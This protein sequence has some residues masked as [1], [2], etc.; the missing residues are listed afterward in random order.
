MLVGFPLNFRF[1]LQKG[2]LAISIFHVRINF[3]TTLVLCH[4]IGTTEY[5]I[6]KTVHRIEESLHKIK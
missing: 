5:R 2:S 4:R 6:E 1:P 3:L